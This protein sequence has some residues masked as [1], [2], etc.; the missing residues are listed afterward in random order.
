MFVVLVSIIYLADLLLFVL[1]FLMV[2]SRTAGT[3]AIV[4]VVLLAVAAYLASIVA[5]VFISSHFS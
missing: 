4:G 2:R 1:V 3:R 5:L